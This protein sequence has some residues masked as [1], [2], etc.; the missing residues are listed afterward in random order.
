MENQGSYGYTIE[1]TDR[2]SAG[3]DSMRRIYFDN[4]STSFPKAPGV[5]EDMKRMMDLGAFGKD[6][7]L[8]S[9]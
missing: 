1:K 3:G 6:V 4:S 8:L 9:K 5:S 2:R 7:L